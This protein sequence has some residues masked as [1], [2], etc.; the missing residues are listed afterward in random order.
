MAN[1]VA[2]TIA[3]MRAI[4]IEPWVATWMTSLYVTP[5]AALATAW[6]HTLQSIVAA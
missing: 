1:L 2:A 3:D 4:T 5:T 6:N